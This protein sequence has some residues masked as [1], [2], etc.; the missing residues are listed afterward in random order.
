M[1]FLLR[2]VIYLALVLGVLVVPLVL[3]NSDWR[4]AAMRGGSDILG[5]LVSLPGQLFSSSE[6]A[7]EDDNTLPLSPLAEQ[8]EHLTRRFHDRNGKLGRF[9]QVLACGAARNDMM[10]ELKGFTTVTDDKG[11]QGVRVALVTGDQ[12]DDLAGSL[13][14]W[15]D[16]R[17]RTCRIQFEGVTGDPG[18]LTSYVMRAQRMSPRGVPVN[19]LFVRDG[20]AGPRHVLHIS[21]PRVVN[22]KT[23]Y[24]RY[25]VALELNISGQQLSPG[26]MKLLEVGS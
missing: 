23:L 17:G 20:R 10:R 18:R 6:P 15:F 14:Y 2:R 16:H 26:S 19:A 7:A 8:M 11:Q 3:L 9:S 4:E 22:L 25:Q 1:R 13:T 24:G 21:R 12:L 5:K